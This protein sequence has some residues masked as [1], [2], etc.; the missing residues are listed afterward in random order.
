MTEQDKVIR[1][2][3]G[4]VISDK[5]DKTRTVKV[6]WSRPHKRYKKV[7]KRKT[8]CQMHDQDNVSRLND[9]VEIKE[10][11]PKSKTKT[12][13]LVRVVEEARS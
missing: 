13:E 11:S 8:T 4:V 1:T 5:R 6:S 2:L 9:V 7:V 12:W 3:T 10:C